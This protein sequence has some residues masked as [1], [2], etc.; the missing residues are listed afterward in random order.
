MKFIGTCNKKTVSVFVGM[1]ALACILCAG[2]FTCRSCGPVSMVAQVLRARGARER[3]LCETDYQ[4]VL[5][6]GREL[7]R[8]FGEEPA[9]YVVNGG[10][11]SPEVSEFPKAIL[12]LA[13]ESIKVTGDGYLII[14]MFGNGMD[15]CGAFL[16]AEGFEKANPGLRLGDRM[17]IPGLW[18]YDDGYTYDPRYDKEVDK[19]IAKRRTRE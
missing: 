1:V 12:D 2:T 10:H 18:Y 8:R 5:D 3:L 19:L 6:A 13:P 4:A 15:H 11:R 9:V 14:E 16:Y 17:L 7:L